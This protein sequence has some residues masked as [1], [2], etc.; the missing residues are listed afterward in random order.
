MKFNFFQKKDMDRRKHASDIFQ[1]RVESK[2]VINIRM[3]IFF[4]CT[5]ILFVALTL[6]LAQLQ[7]LNQ[8][9][10]HEKLVAYTAEIQS[11]QPPRG[12]IIDSDGVVLAQSVR[13]LSISYFIPK[14]I[15][16]KSKEEWE[17][18][19]KFRDKIGVNA[20][21]ITDRQ[22]ADM[23]YAYESVFHKNTFNELV[24]QSEIDD[25]YKAY[26]TSQTQREDVQNA[27]YELKIE[28][29]KIGDIREDQKELYYLMM[30]MTKNPINQYKTVIDDATSE[31]ISHL[32]ENM[33]EFPGFKP[34]SNDW[35]R[36][37]L[38]NETIRSLIG[39][40]ST[41]NQGLPAE[42]S[43][44]YV[45]LDYAL[46]DRVGIS[47]LEK[48]YEKYLKG[49]KTTA[50]ISYDD[51]GVALLNEVNP[52]K[53]G[54][55]LQLTLNLDYQK[56]VDAYA[57]E[58][59]QTSINDSVRQ[60]LENVYIVVMNPTT[61]AILANV[62]VSLDRSNGNKITSI[63]TATYLNAN[64]IGSAVKVATLY[65]G[66]S[67]KVVSP[68]TVIDDTPILI[69]GSE[70][71]SSSQYN[72]KINDI[73]AIAK[74]SNIY[75]GHIAMGMGDAT[76]T[77]SKPLL[78]NNEDVFDDMRVYYNMFGLGVKTG[79]DVPNE[80]IGNIGAT[81]EYGKILDFA[82][83][84]YD[85][86]TTMQLAQYV[87]T[88]ANGGK[89]I[90]PHFLD[91]ISEVNS[92]STILYTE[93]NT[94]LST[95]YGNHIDYLNRAKTGMRECITSGFCGLND[96]NAG[97]SIAA[98]TGTAE[99]EI[100]ENGIA[101]RETVNST[102][103]AYAPYDNPEISI[104]CVIPK[105]RNAETYQKNLCAELVEKTSKYYFDVVK[106]K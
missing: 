37:Y 31:Q 22:I 77:P 66:L 25:L 8:E 41:S 61:G 40:T 81:N 9:V 96:A 36:E 50:K 42:M 82:I 102:M 38:N 13:S 53:N 93:K 87:A 26:A 78:I 68:G 14:S 1:Q 59:L 23:H 67:E 106:N 69:Q 10:Y 35:N 17:L 55:D 39:N 48:Y 76:Y 18:A 52:G 65:M 62:G 86:Y 90:K 85:T 21:T 6:R 73:Q 30:R 95:L 80:E 45:S 43:D 91:K 75:M 100:Y 32:S 70:A 27:I 101:K 19:K 46:N 54:Y 99:D 63:P 92:K 72:G 3:K 64:R 84:Q 51:Q 71:F 24:N 29:M 56:K 88:I 49:S 89:R 12:S 28:R 2:K 98:K 11:F 7:L 44:Y 57:R 5:S 83:G 60:D 79:I 94:I 20:Y 4:I 58:V 97:A 103:V 47:G 16:S 15:N 74:S 104:A 34:I 105:S 33:D